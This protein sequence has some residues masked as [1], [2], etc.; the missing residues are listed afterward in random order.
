[1][2]EKPQEHRSH[3]P[4]RVRPRN[5][6]RVAGHGADSNP[7]G[8]GREADVDARARIPLC[9]PAMH[10]T[11]LSRRR[12]RML[13]AGVLT[14][15]LASAG[16]APAQVFAVGA[17]GTIQND[18]SSGGAPSN[19]AK[20]G[21][22][23]FGEVLL[24]PSTAIQLRVGSFRLPGKEVDSPAMTVTELSVTATYLF[25]EDWFE[26][27]FYG[28]G[29]Y[30]KLS[31]DSPTDLQ[32]PSDLKENV[33]GLKGGVVAIFRIIKSFDF[34]LEGG[35]TYLAGTYAQHTPIVLGAA[36]AYRF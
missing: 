28:G 12:R 6:G 29:G 11:A 25:K 1:M 32:T 9:C 35:V 23:G 36:A 20:A 21:F 3:P 5:G 27:G 16:A 8:G 14:L 30:F 4:P 22:F 17:G 31:P 19:F 24:E 15:L 13:F 2:E 33:W 34:R 26:G 10:E 18:G 7:A